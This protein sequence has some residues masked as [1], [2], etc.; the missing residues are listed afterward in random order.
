MKKFLTADKRLPAALALSALGIA[1]LGTPAFAQ[2]PHQHAT[3]HEMQLRRSTAAVTY[4]GL[5]DRSGSTEAYTPQYVPGYGN[6]G[7]TSGEW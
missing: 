4:Q 7:A 6:I 3:N 2:K 5:V 1:L